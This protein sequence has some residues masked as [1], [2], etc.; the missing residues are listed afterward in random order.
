MIKKILVGLAS[1]PF[2][3]TA[4]RHGIE[5][6]KIH[7][8]QLTGVTIVHA[9]KLEKIGPVPIG[10]G[11]YAEKLRNLH[12]RETEQ[13]A[14]E[15]IKKFELAC[16]AEGVGFHIK[17]E[18]GSPVDVMVSNARYHD[19]TV[20]GSR[21]LFD[22]GV[23]EEPKYLLFRLIREGVRPIVACPEK[24][25]SVRRVLMAYNGS[26]ESAATIK[27][28][29][30]L[31]PWPETEVRII[32]FEKKCPESE[33]LLNDMKGYCLFHGV[34]AETLLLQGNPKEDLIKY[35]TDWNADMIVMGNSGRRLLSYH[36]FG[37]STSYA[38][39]HAE[40]ALFLSQ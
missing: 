18:K 35:A 21:Q 30:Q 23:I 28:W 20:I 34:Q 19:L 24:F 14:E 17:R 2:T 16:T 36:L 1:T 31:N 6:A 10:G 7:H 9:S 15:D 33:Q 12:V 40:Q 39:A 37:D 26:I 11:H 29:I 25:R 5:L 27:K 32:Y 8:A 13:H 38:I 4:I 3:E 22:Y